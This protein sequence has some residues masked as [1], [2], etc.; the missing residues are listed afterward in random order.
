MEN[1]YPKGG[2]SNSADIYSYYSSHI[3]KLRTKSL[4]VDSKMQLLSPGEQL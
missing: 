4:P 3:V 1:V 2:V